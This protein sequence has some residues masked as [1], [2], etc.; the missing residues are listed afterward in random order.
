MRIRI[1][2]LPVYIPYVLFPLFFVVTRSMGYSYSRSWIDVVW[3]LLGL[4]AA[5][6]IAVTGRLLIDRRKFL[7]FSSAIALFAAIVTVK[8]G[9][10]L[11]EPVVLVPFVME[12]KPVLYLAVALLWVG[13][14]GNIDPGQFR[15]AGVWLAALMVFDFLLESA[16]AGEA[17]KPLGSGEINY[18]ACLLLISFCTW[19]YG[20][21]SARSYIVIF[22]GILAT[23]S[24][25]A[26]AAIVVIS[27]F[28]GRAGLFKK[29][30]IG[31]VCVLFI[32]ASFLVRD[33]PLDSLERM[34]RFWMWL[35]GLELI[36]GDLLQSLIGFPSGQALPVNIPEELVW[37]WSSQQEGWGIEGVFPFH[38]HS[39]W[40]R[41][42]I[43][44]GL[45]AVA[46]AFIASAYIVFDRKKTLFL[47]TLV[48]L[49]VL[50]GLTMGVVYLS[51]VAVPLMLAVF[52]A[53]SAREGPQEAAG[54]TRI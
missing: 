3:I 2:S 22:I 24:R 17:I 49:A 15:K 45:V 53:V 11:F 29:M 51:N 47:R 21:E 39:F 16:L 48:F 28:F 8:F 19:F 18:D 36:S 42:A 50:E 32:L 23:L 1:S 27:F 12:L 9:A 20:H 38:F 54:K 31:A 34:D 14:F 44:W 37:L 25:T 43:T 46:L 5:V 10:S 26:L 33:L 4:F 7:F 6:W 35:A 13:A 30:L 40:L 41:F 52:S